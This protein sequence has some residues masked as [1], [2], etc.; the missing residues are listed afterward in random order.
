[1]WDHA[2]S[3][4]KMGEMLVFVK[5]GQLKGNLNGSSVLIR[6]LILYY[7]VRPAMFFLNGVLQLLRDDANI[8]YCCC[9]I[10]LRTWPDLRVFEVL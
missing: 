2:H 10:S 3:P 9:L 7:Q 1:M 5:T 4:T 6:V 8:R